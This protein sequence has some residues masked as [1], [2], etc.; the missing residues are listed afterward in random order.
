MDALI[1]S[2]P[3][4]PEDAIAALVVGVVVGLVARF[5]ATGPLLVVAAAGVTFE[6]RHG[7][8][9]DA[10]VDRPSPLWAL[11]G[12]IV[13]AA[14]IAAIAEPMRHRSVRAAGLVAGVPLAAVWGLV[15][16][17]EAP[18]IGGMVLLGAVALGLG[19]PGVAVLATAVI[20]P[21][22]ALVG[23]VGRP[24]QLLLALVAAVGWAVVTRVGL[25]MLGW[26]R[27]RQRA[28]TPVTVAPAATSSTTT[29]PAPTTAP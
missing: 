16:D 23:S 2:G 1:P 6:R 17:T 7:G 3:L 18:L 9:G 24:S 19:R 14:L 29:A 21:V 22:A 4:H 5:S 11:L 28:G 25:E 15:A 20:A 13:A 8:L 12:V 26:R 27:R 10:F